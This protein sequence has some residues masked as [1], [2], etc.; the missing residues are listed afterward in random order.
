MLKKLCFSILVLFTLTGQAQIVQNCPR[1]IA[2]QQVMGEFVDS[3]KLLEFWTPQ[4]ERLYD[5]IPALSPKEEKWLN[6]E[7][8]SNLDRST[9][10]MGTQEFAM[11][12]AKRQLGSLLGVIRFNLN[13][14]KLLSHEGWVSLS[15]Y[16]VS[17]PDAGFYI[18]KLHRLGVV[19]DSVIPPIWIYGS[20][21][22]INASTFN[23]GQRRLATHILGCIIPQLKK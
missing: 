2:S 4:I 9:K 8:K 6:D 3:K 21:D 15:Y 7:L 1:D 11:V 17:D 13:G 20:F 10:A 16:L 12:A 19:K 23:E 14:N 22:G 18:N 5:S